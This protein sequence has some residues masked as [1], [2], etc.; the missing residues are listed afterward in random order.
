MTLEIHLLGGFRLAYEGKL[1]EAFSS[2]RLQSLLGYLVLHRHMPQPR[3]QLAFLFWPD[4]SEAQARTNLRRELHQ[5]RQ[6]LPEAERFL[7]I[8]AATLQWRS[9]APFALDVGEFEDAVRQAEEAKDQDVVRQALEEAVSL[10]HGDLLPGLY[11]EWVLAE[12]ERLRQAYLGAL[13]R[14]VRLLEEAREYALAIRHGQRL[15]QLDPLHEA[16]YRRLMRLHAL[17]G[18]RARALHVYH[19]CATVLQRELDI[20]PSPATQEAYRRLLDMDALAQ[21]NTP[22]ATPRVEPPARESPGTVFRAT[23]LPLVG[24]QREWETLLATWRRAVSKQAHFMAI[25]G[26]AG[27]GKTRLAEELLEWTGQQGIAA[28]RTRCYAAEGRLAYAPVIELL[29]ADALKSSRSRLEDAWLTEVARLLPEVLTERPELPRPQPLTEAWQRR[30]L[31]EA[32]ARAVLAASQ[33][34]LLLID[35]LQWCDRDTLEWLH[36]LLRFDPYAK[37]LVTCTIRSEELEDNQ[38]LNTLLLN[39][40]KEGQLIEIELGPLDLEETAELAAA[41]TG[42]ELDAELRRQVFQET[43][44]Q[45]LFVVETARAGFKLKDDTLGTTPASLPP[46]VQAVIAARLAQLSS[47]ARE[48]AQLAAT[49]GRA[50]TFEVL[51]G[52][53]DLDE[54]SLVQALDELWG[55]RIVREQGTDT[56]DFSHDRIREVAYSEVGPIKRRLLHRRVA[57]AL[58]LLHAANIDAVSAELA[59]HYE[60]AGQMAKA[61]EFYKRAAEVARQVCANEEAIRLLSRALELL[62]QLPDNAERDKQELAL[63]LTLSSPLNAARGYT[64][65]ELEAA[66]DRA[67]LLGERLREDN[68][69]I[70]SL[71]GLCAVYFVRANLR[72]SRQLGERMFGLAQQSATLLPESHHALG[73]SLTSLG[74]LARAKDHF[75]QAVA[76]CDPHYQRPR[77]SVFGSDLGVFGY[78]WMAH[79]L[80]LLGYP[81]RAAASSRQAISLAQ[82][83]DHPYSLALANAY[84]AILYQ[85]RRDRKACRAC[86]EAALALCTKHGFAYYGEWGLILQGWALSKEAPEKESIARIRRGLAS[87]R[88]VNAETRRPYYL[89]LLSG[90]HRN[91]GQLDEAREVLDEALATAQRNHDLWW[92]AELHRLKGELSAPPSAEACFHKALEIARQQ[93]SKSLELRAAVSLARLWRQQGRPKEAR[94]LVQEVYGW[95]TEGFDT[96]DLKE[97]RALLEELP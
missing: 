90:A 28:A 83:L 64:A 13:E 30:H 26:E 80:W 33:P 22:R 17:N 95:F 39:L 14:L 67:R 1:V 10:Y 74:E 42:Q 82:E 27:I 77:T 44:G 54:E 36:Y 5:L 25:V 52:A 73:G 84:A 43:E 85:L 37:L 46:K 89:S 49:I 50:F 31:F 24:R 23:S 58:E 57:Q 97:A 88:A 2:L 87:L 29:R 41:V 61:I 78:A 91:V 20:E 48:L 86:A 34:L 65:P 56:Y 53:S 93:A 94:Q 47:Q 8:D 4:S 6:A 75:E 9:E 16:S 71:W 96:A 60:Q 18:D 68:Q 32:L 69:L 81:D 92:S 76:H 55:R 59:R 70:H 40:R 38:A 12:R 72:K 7:R 66:L 63:L 19:N 11:D 45:P 51:G 62:K 35:D 79:T 15:L 21:D 3:H